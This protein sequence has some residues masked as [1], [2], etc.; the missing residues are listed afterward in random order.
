MGAF[1]PEPMNPDDDLTIRGEIGDT[2]VAELLRS[3][4]G[5][6]ETGILTLRNGDVTKSIYIQAGRVLYAASTNV[7]ERLGESLLLR[8]RITARQYLEASKMIRPGRRLGAILV[9]LAALEPEELT[10]AVEHQVKEI[11][12]DLFTWTHGSYELV[13]KDLSPDNVVSLNI[14]TENLILEGIRRVRA[15]SQLMRGLGD[16]GVVLARASGPD[17]RLE[18]SPE[19]QEVLAQ[20][21]GR[22]TVE[23]ICDVSYLTHF[24]TCRIL[25]GLQVLGVVVRRGQ[26]DSA[27]EDGARAHERELDLEGIVEKFNQMFGRIYVFLQGRLGREVDAFMDTVLDDVSR[28]YGSLFAGVDLKQ[29]GRADFE[30][31]LAN[32]ADLPPEQRKSLMVAGLNELVFVIQLSV[33][34]RF[35]KE[36]E[37]VVSG[38]IKEGFRR[39]GAA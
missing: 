22:S 3:L 28:Q 9:E 26:K 20:V 31:M 13:I 21:N 15:W 11:L 25:W 24:E 7:D 35:G 2:S 4:L 16:I 29:Y 27:A 38:I 36:E 37:A 39:L 6:G 33:R 18:L 8:G 17:H 1:D 10:A 5:S 23:Q 34:T 32:I 12:M 30:Q 19:E 14:S